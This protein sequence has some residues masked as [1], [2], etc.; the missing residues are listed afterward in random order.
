[1]FLKEFVGGG[2]Q[3]EISFVGSSLLSVPG[4]NPCGAWVKFVLGVAGENRARSLH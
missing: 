2:K 4:G 3:Q 1:M